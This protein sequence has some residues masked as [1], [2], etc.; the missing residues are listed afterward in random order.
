[1]GAKYFLI[2]ASYDKCIIKKE[3][4]RKLKDEFKVNFSKWRYDMAMIRKRRK[5]I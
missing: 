1:M 4:E 5:T 3:P 2:P